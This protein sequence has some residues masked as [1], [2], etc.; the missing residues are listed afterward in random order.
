MRPCIFC[1]EVVFL[2]YILNHIIDI[3]YYQLLRGMDMFN[4][5]KSF[6]NGKANLFRAIFMDLEISK[7][8]MPKVR[9]EIVGNI[10]SFLDEEIYL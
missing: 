8:D 9:V 10:V 2:L 1:K 6:L 3:D 5:T 4:T 7:G